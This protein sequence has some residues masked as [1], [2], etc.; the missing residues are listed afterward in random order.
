MRC[1]RSFLLVGY[2]LL[3]WAI[4]SVFAV[5]QTIP[6]T[7]DLIRDSEC[8]VHAPVGYLDSFWA[9]CHAM[10]REKSVSV[11]HLGDSHVQA[12]H[13]SM[14]VREGFSYLFGSGGVGLVLPYRI[15]GTNEPQHASMRVTGR[16]WSGSYITKRKYHSPS[17]TGCYIIS[18]TDSPS[19]L[20]I[21]S[22]D[23]TLIDRVVV[24][25]NSRSGA[26]LLRGGHPYVS[27]NYVGGYDETYKDTLKLLI[28]RSEVEITAPKR[29][30]LFGVSLERDDLGVILHTVGY[31]GAFFSTYTEDN[32]LPSLVKHLEP[33]LIIISLGTNEALVS[34]FTPSL[35][36][37]EMRRIVDLVR[38][39]DP[40]CKV[41][42]T[43]PLYAYKRQRVRRGVYEY[44]S[45][46][47][48]KVVAQTM[49]AES[50][51][52][53]CAFVDLYSIF[54]GEAE[55]EHLVSRGMLSKDHI[56]LTVDGYKV[57]GE[58]LSLALMRDYRRYLST[59]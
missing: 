40:E 39:Q 14:P 32:Y 43:S 41:L 28:P 34:R 17:P 51:T 52:L 16:G 24:Y 13:F 45:N 49:R 46:P 37:M 21:K 23:N 4:S 3:S 25:R 59:L 50:E 2:I 47:N 9:E 12:G 6:G 15:L 8:Y 42:F 48:C 35:I 10:S 55:K 33:K 11:V 54:G 58:A 31:N 27:M 7:L 30:E 57:L 38:S 20:T 1:I 56:H 29:G 36:T 5:A 53:G 22:K 19:N 44:I 26:F 18:R